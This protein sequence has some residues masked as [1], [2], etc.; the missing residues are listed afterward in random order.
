MQCIYD[1]ATYPQCQK[2]MREEIRKAIE[3]EGRLTLEKLTLLVSVDSFM[4]EVIRLRPGTLV[5][6]A[7]KAVR[8]VRLSDGLVIPQ[9]VTVAMPSFALNQD[10]QKFGA[11][12]AEFKPF[13]FVDETNRS[14]ASLSF[15]STL[16]P[17]L[18]FG[19]GKASCPGRHLALW[20]IKVILARF[21]LGYEVQ[22]KPGTQR[23]ASIDAG[24]HK[25]A[26]LEGRILCRKLS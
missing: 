7:R 26:D 22:L 15:E 19:Y 24:V 9:G 14:P 18:D 11:D 17:G 13:R 10:P 1:M 16:G 12:A 3:P 8:E 25:I 6:M 4:K 2:L 23:P 21:I 5:V 20:T